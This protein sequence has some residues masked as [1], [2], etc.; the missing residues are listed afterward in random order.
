MLKF[1]KE[2]GHFQFML[3]ICELKNIFCKV[4]NENIYKKYMIMTLTEEISSLMF[5]LI[6]HSDD[7]KVTKCAIDI[8]EN[9]CSKWRKCLW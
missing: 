2:R 9:V 6:M 8:H 1:E 5:E 3:Q 4:V 7:C